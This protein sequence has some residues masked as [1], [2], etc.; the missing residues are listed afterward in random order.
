MMLLGLWIK[1]AFMIFVALV[2]LGLLYWGWRNGQFRDP[3]EPKFRML[4]DREPEPW[5]DRKGD[6][7]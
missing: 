1:V 4:E 5:P 3:E 6:N 2:A 7:P